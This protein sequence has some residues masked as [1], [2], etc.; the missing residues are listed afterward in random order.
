MGFIFFSYFWETDVRTPDTGV[1]F[2]CCCLMFVCLFVCLFVFNQYIKGYIIIYKAA[3]MIIKSLRATSLTRLSVSIKLPLS[4]KLSTFYVYPITT[5]NQDVFHS[6]VW[7]YIR[8]LHCGTHRHDIRLT[9]TCQPLGTTGNISL[10]CHNSCVS[11]NKWV[12][13]EREWKMFSVASMKL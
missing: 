6:S 5:V 10:N 8:G 11:G 13:G 7:V 12:E 3:V 2:C 4:M 1:V 9:Q